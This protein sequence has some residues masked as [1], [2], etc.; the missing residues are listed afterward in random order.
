MGKRSN[1]PETSDD[2]EAKG[3]DWMNAEVARRLQGFQTGGWSQGR[4]SFFQRLVW[5]ESERERLHGVI[6]PTRRFGR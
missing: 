4:K 5:V 3:L 6:A 2:P 1:A